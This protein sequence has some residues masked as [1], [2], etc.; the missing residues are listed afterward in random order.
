MFID[1]TA[2][3]W[4]NYDV[5]YDKFA[6]Y[7]M[8]NLAG[9]FFFQWTAGAKDLPAPSNVGPDWSPAFDAGNFQSLL[10]H[11]TSL[12]TL[13]GA[14]T[15]FDCLPPTAPAS[16]SDPTEIVVD[17]NGAQKTY[18]GF[19]FPLLGVEAAGKHAQTET[20]KLKALGANLVYLD[21]Q[22]YGS[23]PKGPDGGHLDQKATSPWSKTMRQGY[24]A[25][26]G[27]FNQM[28]GTLVGPLLGEGSIGTPNANMEYLY[29]GY[30]D[31]VQRTINTGGGDKAA[32]LPA[33]SPFAPT[34]WPIIPE[35]EWRVAAKRQ[36][37]HGNGFYDRFFGPSDGLSIVQSDG[38]PSYPL[39]QNALDLYQAFLISYGHAGFLITN[40]TDTPQD[41]LSYAQA[42]QIY[43]MSNAL[44]ALYF[45]SPIAGIHYANQGEWKTFE[46]IISATESLDSFRHVPVRLDFENGL[47]ITVNNGAGPLTMVDGGLTYTLPA[48]TGWY[49]SMGNGW[50]R[51]FSAIPPGTNGKRIDYVKATGQ[52]EYFNGRG[53][54]S[55]YGGIT[56]STKRSKWTI[57]PMNSTVTE[58]SAGKLGVSTGTPPDLLNVA[59]LP[60]DDLHLH[61]GDQAGLKSVANFKNGGLFDFTTLL[62]WYSTKPGVAKVNQA[63]VVTA[64]SSGK[65]KIIAVGIGGALVSTPVTV[66][67]N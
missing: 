3:V 1:G 11:G 37:N 65:A 20:G 50:F 35:Y 28:R 26:K 19:G 56:T 46:Q 10:Q 54:V 60:A 9:Y 41:Y 39:S 16:V 7:G 44:Q 53:Q 59:L 22:T 63:G 61:P 27:W 57:T 49:A 48:D 6:S 66:F 43:F 58:D 21:I 45:A 29:N 18:N 33:G 34:N 42:A 12:G 64:V 23:I 15:A 8:F 51:A 38:N 25:Q 5:M 36:V 4:S 67:V 62:T 30:V 14:Y 52:Y 55:G 40:G 24:A 2:S 47:R 31:S 32:D 13:L 17:S